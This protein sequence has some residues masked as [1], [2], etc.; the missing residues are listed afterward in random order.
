MRITQFTGLKLIIFLLI[1]FPFALMSG[2]VC[3]ETQYVSDQLVITM[4]EGRGNEYK[5][6]KM[7]KTGTPLEIIDEGEKYLKVRTEDGSEGW[8]LK[9]YVTKD[10]PKPEIIAG[11]EKEIDLLNTRIE[12]HKKDEKSL[13]DKLNATRSEHNNSIRNLQHTMSAVSANAEQTSKDLKEITQKYDALL[14]D[15]KDV[16]LLAQERD[17]IKASNRDLLSRTEQ[18]Q[19][20]NDE[21]KRSQMIWWFAAGGGVFFVGWIV[22]K[23]SRQKKFY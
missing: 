5:I 19:R 23:I 16:V 10:I 15:S 6:I 17:N 20:E 21:L 14:K 7:L 1:L 22:G 9:Q 11:L 18:L 3:A 8:V 4:R 13:Q 12:Q 2:I